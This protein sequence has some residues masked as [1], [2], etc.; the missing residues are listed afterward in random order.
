MKKTRKLS[1]VKGKWLIVSDELDK[2]RVPDET[3]K[4]IKKKGYNEYFELF[5]DDRIMYYKG[6]LHK[7]NEDDFGHLDWAMNDS[8]CTYI[9]YRNKDGKM[10]IL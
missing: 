1:G 2:N 7:D 5:D 10:E 8:G 6:Y 3:I 4:E 9:K